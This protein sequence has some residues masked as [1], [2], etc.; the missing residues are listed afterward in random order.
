MKYSKW[1]HWTSTTIEWRLI[2][3]FALVVTAVA[4]LGLLVYFSM[5]KIVRGVEESAKPDERSYLIKIVMSQISDAEGYI[6]SYTITNDSKYLVPYTETVK[7]VEA[8]V[9]RLKKM[10]AKDSSVA[11]VDTLS[12][13]LKLKFAVLENYISTRDSGRVQSILQ[14]LSTRAGAGIGSKPIK[15]AEPGFLKKLFGSGKQH[16]TD[17]TVIPH[18]FKLEIDAL[19]NMEAE[20][21]EER[22]QV[23]LS[24]TN[25]DEVVMAR[26]RNL[27]NQIE[28]KYQHGILAQT[29]LAEQLASRTNFLIAVFC[30]ALTLM[31]LLMCYVIVSYVRKLREITRQLAIA[32][33]NSDK[34]AA[35][36]EMF[37]ANMSHEIR[38]PLHAIIGFSGQLLD[39]EHSGDIRQD[40][41]IIKKS[42]EYLL[43]LINNILDL[44]RLES[45]KFVPEAK[46][47][48]P[49]EAIHDTL[50]IVQPMIDEKG[51]ILTSIGDLEHMAMVEGDSVSLKQILINLLANAIKYTDQGTVSVIVNSN[52]DVENKVLHL[53]IEISDTGKGIPGDK[54]EIVF[55]EYEQETR[56]DNAKFSGTGLGLT[57][58]KKL[59]TYLGG[60][61]QLNSAIGEGTSVK[62]KLPFRLSDIIHYTNTTAKKQSV[63]LLKG[64]HILIADDELYNIKLLEAFMQKWECLYD[65]CHDG[66]K[67]VDLLSGNKYDVILLDKRMPGFSGIEISKMIA[68][69]ANHINHQTP[70]I[71]LTAGMVEGAYKSRELSGIDKTIQKPF[72]ET[73]L[74]AAMLEILVPADNL[75]AAGN[76]EIPEVALSGDFEFDLSGLKEMAGGD[77]EF[78]REM[79][80]IFIENTRKNFAKL[81]YGVKNLI[82]NDIVEMA[83]VML[84]PCRHLH[85]LTIAKLLETIGESGRRK[86][87]ND[88][89]TLCTTLGE[90]LNREICELQKVVDQN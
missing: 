21:F 56:M 61:I 2:L 23:L 63:S 33:R 76:M 47:F 89:V 87:D 18:D 60:N 81:E 15:S 55:E 77:E 58:A 73:E 39:P 67:A 66:M 40:V 12:M 72:T 83:H 16:N 70:V 9:A 49:G 5:N 25:Q 38:T 14:E 54:Q 1:K 37:L 26:I 17:Q 32:R 68:G 82:W 7:S 30:A 45:G 46:L 44:S 43:N 75:D 71:L 36:K 65:A 62:V 59:V 84:P 22:A 28:L 41:E 90:L 79:L 42:S 48:N 51:L 52:T 24:I 69:D 31:L 4:G 57:I 53:D 50:M 34:L 64:K 8:N 13:L 35:T 85:L 74:V 80:A 19:R 10:Q 20:N 3:G 27:I 6:K 86:Y 11:M 88:L 29:N 78:T